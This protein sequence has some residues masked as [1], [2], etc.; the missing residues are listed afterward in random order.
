MTSITEAAVAAGAPLVQIRTKAESDRSRYDHAMR[1]HRVCEVASALCLVNDRVDLAQA[2]R[3]DG[4]HLGADDLSV[5]LARRILGDGAVI[6]GTARDPETARRLAGEGATYLGVGPAYATTT[7]TGL[8]DPIGVRGVEAVAAA[9]D[10]PVIA[11]GGVTVERVPELLDAGAWGVAAVGAVYGHAD[12][13]AAVRG[14]LDA[15]DQGR[16]R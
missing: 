8:P 16:S 13:V 6:G 15:I 4:V 9:V 2:V 10:I 14:L 7:K 5:A 3:G 12:P 11:I 1:L